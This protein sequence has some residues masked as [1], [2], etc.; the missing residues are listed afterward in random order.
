MANDEDISTL[1]ILRNLDDLSNPI[2]GRPIIT[3][4]D[5]NVRFLTV[6]LQ[7]TSSENQ[8]KILTYRFMQEIFHFLG[9]EKSILSDTRINILKE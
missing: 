6:Y 8:N 2:H 3:L 9:F 5:Y 7:G 1:S 4:I